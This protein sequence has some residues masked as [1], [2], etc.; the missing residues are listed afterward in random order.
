MRRSARSPRDTASRRITALLRRAGAE[1][2]LADSE[3]DAFR[4]KAAD[5]IREAWIK[6]MS[7]QGLPAQELYDLVMK[8]LKEQRGM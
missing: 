6:D 5:P 4:S 8:T 3:L 1:V 7:A 2:E